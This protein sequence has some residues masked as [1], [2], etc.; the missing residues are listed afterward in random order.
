MDERT[1][2][3]AGHRRRLLSAWLPVGAWAA[4]IFLASATPDLRFL[5]DQSADLVVRKIGHLGAYGILAL[6]AW[7]AIASTTNLRPPWVWALVL[8]IVYAA[9]D[10]LHQASVAGR[11]AAVSDVA[12]DAAGAVIAVGVV[13]LV[14]S[15]RARHQPVRG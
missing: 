7:R 6:L 11:S 5:P 2:D 13:W 1:D 8:G 14:Q 10:E 4:L 9:S 12:L 3:S 15:Q